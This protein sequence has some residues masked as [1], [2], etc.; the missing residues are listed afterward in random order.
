MI[1]D[2]HRYSHI[3][4]P[5]T[6]LGVEDRASVTVVAGDGATADALETTVYI[7]GPERG[8]K[9]VD[10]TP[11]AAAIFVR[12]TAQ[13]IKTFESTRFKQIPKLPPEAAPK[14]RT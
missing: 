5:K 10:E 7:L 13:G 8:L 11:G 6:G 9:L 4:D 12:S 14:P 1:L 2:G 3:V